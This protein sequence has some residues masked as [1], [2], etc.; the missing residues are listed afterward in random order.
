MHVPP[1]TKGFKKSPNKSDFFGCF[2]EVF[3]HGPRR[4]KLASAGCPREPKGYLGHAKTVREVQVLYYR[5]YIE[6]RKL[7]ARIR[8]NF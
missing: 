3:Q 4:V 7:F 1:S 5:F 8:S 2:S 6:M